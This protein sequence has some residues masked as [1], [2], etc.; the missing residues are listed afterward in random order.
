MVISCFRG[1]PVGAIDDDR[2]QAS[3]P[4]TLSANRKSSR[5]IKRSGSD[6]SRLS[7]S[8]TTSSCSN[9]SISKLPPCKRQSDPKIEAMMMPLPVEHR[10]SKNLR[11]TCPKIHSNLVNDMKASKGCRDWRNF[12]VFYNDDVDMSMTA[13][14]AAR[15]RALEYQRRVKEL[16]SSFDWCPGSSQS[17]SVDMILP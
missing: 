9:E 5:F 13:D 3:R 12:A 17:A 15:Q 2:P 14:E 10:P 16:N 7:N 11:L 8:S 4:A 1:S 6:Q